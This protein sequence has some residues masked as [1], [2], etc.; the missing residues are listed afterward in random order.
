MEKISGSL[1]RNLQELY[2]AASDDSGSKMELVA[3]LWGTR[4]YYAKS[5]WGKL[6]CVFYCIWAIFFG[7]SL[8]QHK[9]KEMLLKT[10][11]LFAEQTREIA[12]N[13]TSYKKNLIVLLEEQDNFNVKKYSLHRYQI[14][15]WN[16]ATKPLLTLLHRRQNKKITATTGKIFVWN[17]HKKTHT[18]AFQRKRLFE[19]LHAYQ[20]IINIERR[21]QVE[22]PLVTLKK[23]SQMKKLNKEEE[24]GLQ[25][26]IETLNKQ[27]KQI[28]VR[29]FHKG[30]EAL[31]GHIKK[32]HWM[33]GLVPPSLVALELALTKRNCRIFLRRDPKH[34]A[35]R[36]TIKPGMALSGC[37]TSLHLM[38]ELKPKK[39]DPSSNNIV[40]TVKDNADKVVVIGKNRALLGIKKEI[41]DNLSWGCLSATWHEVDEEGRFA[42]VERLREPLSSL[43]WTST[44]ENITPSDQCEAHPFIGQL[45][46]CLQKELTPENFSYKNFMFC[47]KGILK[48]TKIPLKGPLNLPGLESFAR[49]VARNNVHV[50][51]YIMQESGLSFHSYVAY[52]K[53][54][55]EA[56]LKGD[57][58]IDCSTLAAFD[59]HQI[60]DPFVI[61]QAKQL[62]VEVTALHHQCMEE[63]R[64]RYH[65]ENISKASR[66]AAKAIKGLYLY[67]GTISTLW[68]SLKKDTIKHVA[69]KMKLGKN[70]S[71]SDS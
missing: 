14:S 15:H 33:Q 9:L 64:R 4:I 21:L 51:R 7:T 48:S 59:R 54:V 50:F 30:L 13:F 49:K 43:K 69:A 41:A 47:R 60:T 39:S 58:E 56:A 2:A 29:Q 37:N 61:K 1:S 67:S 8:R 19:E 55:V 5:G 70:E 17:L 23:L 32:H 65:I 45:K 40:F 53:E 31:V 34:I 10:E 26:W 12:K 46:W 36:D 71:S 27:D 20:N 24:A 57:E 16:D 18:A 44:S 11:R 38:R 66:C 42:L 62:K 35:W 28:T 3:N 6:W 68:P 22:T 25:R 52:F 63:L